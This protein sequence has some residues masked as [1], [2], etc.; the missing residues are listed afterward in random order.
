LFGISS[1]DTITTTSRMSPKRAAAL[2]LS[3][4]V[5]YKAAAK[6]RIKI[7]ANTSVTTTNTTN[8]P[9][10]RHRGH[11]TLVY[12]LQLVADWDRGLPSSDDKWT[13]TLLLAFYHKPSLFFI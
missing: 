11:R 7:W 2:V 12:H 1:S 8:G 10:A 6:E 4:T 13:D 5:P 3:G 9:H